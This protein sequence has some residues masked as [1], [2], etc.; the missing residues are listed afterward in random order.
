MQGSRWTPGLAAAVMATGCFSVPPY[1]PDNAVSFTASAAGGGTATGAGFALRFADGPGFHFPDK[2]LIDDA[3]VMGH[4]QAQTCFNEDEV[5]FRIVPTARIT[6]TGAAPAVK[7][8]LVPALRGP[9]VTQVK[10][11][12]ATQFNCDATRAPGG[13]ST[14]TMFPD[15][16]IVRFDTIADAVSNEIV[17]SKCACET[18]SRSED[19]LFTISTHWTLARTSFETLSFDSNTNRLP[20]DGQEVAAN[21]DATCIA[22]DSYQVAV[23]W[24]ASMASP[25]GLRTATRGR[26]SLIEFRRDLDLGASQLKAFSYDNSS[27]IFIERAGCDAAFKRANEHARPSALTINGTSMKPSI[28]DGIYGGDA[29]DGLPPGIDLPDK[30]AELSGTVN[31]SFAVWLRFPGSTDAIHATLAGKTGAWYM[32]Q[33]VDDRTWIVWFR[34]PIGAGQ[35]VTVEPR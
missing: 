30:R 29:G 15:G 27:A 19:L 16:R 6:A 2:L 14:Y 12:W 13:T 4:D 11:D 23:A 24:P 25:M 22:R 20:D 32:P 31:S 3:D 7:N 21:F 18:P 17:P 26:A 10:L 35:T 28:R 33:Q 34:D 5:G 1:E 9:A 8:L